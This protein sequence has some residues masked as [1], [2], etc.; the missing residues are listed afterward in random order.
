ML[1]GTAVSPVF[2]L[3]GFSYGLSVTYSQCCLRKGAGIAEKLLELSR[4]ASEIY[5]AYLEM[6]PKTV[7]TKGR[8]ILPLEK[9][10]ENNNHVMSSSFR[11]QEYF[12]GG[13]G[14]FNFKWMSLP[15]Y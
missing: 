8:N 9:D 2:L 11:I 7:F 6:N 3:L 10:Q 13:K 14:G 4:F 12:Q 15:F 5:F 1:L